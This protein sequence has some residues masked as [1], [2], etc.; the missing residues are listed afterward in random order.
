MKEKSL[1]RP[2][3][4]LILV[5]IPRIETRSGGGIILHTEG[6]PAERKRVEDSRQTGILHSVGQ[7]G[8]SDIG[9]GSPW[10]EVGDKVYF[11]RYAGV[12]YRD[13]DDELYRIM[14]NDDIMAVFPIEEDDK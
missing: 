3:G 9:D 7:T 5:H 2:C 1:P 13:K 4:H 6:D 14:N 8:W 11:K 12:E 10:A